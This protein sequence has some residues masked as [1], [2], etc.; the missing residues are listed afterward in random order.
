[1][2]NGMNMCDIHGRPKRVLSMSYQ[3]KDSQLELEETKKSLDWRRKRQVKMKEG[4]Q[5]S[6]MPLTRSRLPRGQG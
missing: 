4:C 5:A 3:Q 2:Y 1:M 6:Q